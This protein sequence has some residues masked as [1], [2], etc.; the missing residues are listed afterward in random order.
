[1]PKRVELDSRPAVNEMVQG[2][3]TAD[4]PPPFTECRAWAPQA[5]KMWKT[6][7]KA[8]GWKHPKAPSVRHL[9]EGEATETV[10]DFLRDTR[11]GCMVNVRRHPREE[12]GGEEREEGEGGIN[13]EDGPGPP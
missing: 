1:M 3:E 2:R 9:W 5:R 12:E 4:P 6:T 13:E 8:C 11:V 7:G 10:L